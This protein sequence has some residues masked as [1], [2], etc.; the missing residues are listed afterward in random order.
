MSDDWVR[1]AGYAILY[2]DQADDGR[3]AVF[4]AGAFHWRRL[5]LLYQHDHRAESLAHTDDGT[6]HVWQDWLGLA[7]SAALPRYSAGRLVRFIR[8]TDGIGMSIGEQCGCKFDGA[9]IVR[10]SISEISITYRPAYPAGGVW[11]A[12][13]EPVLPPRL[14]GLARHWRAG[15]PQ[16]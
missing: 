13:D 3:S 2:H 11:V 10:A 1:L 6:L 7:F 12:G 15:V 8:E 5:R 9:T 14:A 4:D 16:C